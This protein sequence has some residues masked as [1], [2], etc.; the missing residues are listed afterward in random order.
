MSKV[1]PEDLDPGQPALYDSPP[2]QRKSS[3]GSNGKL[4]PVNKV[5]PESGFE[6]N[7]ENGQNIETPELPDNSGYSAGETKVD[8]QDAKPEENEKWGTGLEDNPE[9]LP[10]QDLY[11][12]L[13]PIDE[14]R[15]VSNE[16]RKRSELEIYL[17]INSTSERPSTSECPPIN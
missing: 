13:P 3:A 10:R 12:K 8:A 17:L 5:S 6:E 9:V 14:T 4:K 2:G 11:G 15:P 16:R 1:A 7:M